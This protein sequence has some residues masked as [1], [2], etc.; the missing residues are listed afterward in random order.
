MEDFKKIPRVNGPYKKFRNQLNQ[1]ATEDIWYVLRAYMNYLQFEQPFPSDIEYPLNIETNRNR[2]NGVIYEWELAFIAR[3]SLRFGQVLNAHTKK[4][5]RLFQNFS[6]LTTS[7]VTFKEALY[8]QYGNPQNVLQEFERMSHEQ[9]PWQE[10]MRFKFDRYY[11]LYSYPNMQPYFQEKF[12][13]SVD[14]WYKLGGTV[15]GWFLNNPTAPLD[16]G[17]D[18]PGL[19][20]NDLRVFLETVSRPINVLKDKLLETKYN[21]DFQYSFNPLTYYPVVQIEESYYCPIVPYLFDKM[22]AGLYYDM[23]DTKYSSI[24]GDAFHKYLQKRSELFLNDTFRIIPENEYKDGKKKKDSVD[25]IV[26]NGYSAMFIEAKAKQLSLPSKTRMKKMKKDISIISQA[27]VQTYKN[28]EAYCDN[29]YPHFPYSEEIQVFPVVVTMEEWYNIGAFS[30]EIDK[31]VRRQLSEAQIPF[32][33]LYS[34][35]YTICSSHSYE[36]LLNVLDRYKLDTVFNSW[37][38]PANTGHHLGQF[39]ST[40]FRG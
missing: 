10:N 39:L 19:T 17:I 28:I 18:V 35:P 40:N 1:Y 37:L 11:Q 32:E 34:H 6:K 5:I 12:G 23:V 15:A 16:I 24:L 29:L 3:E 7:C 27:V 2:P 9:F 30:N 22:G 26:V 38:N 33:I 36:I 4:D 14:D 25:F 21:E 31:E 13:M 20:E 8:Q